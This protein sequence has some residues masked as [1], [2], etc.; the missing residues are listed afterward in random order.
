MNILELLASEPAGLSLSALAERMGL[1]PQTC[2]SLL[3]TLETHNM[4]RQP[5]RGQAYRLGPAIGALARTWSRRQRPPEQVQTA[6]SEL[7]RTTGEYVILA[8]LDGPV[9]IPLAEARPD[10]PLVVAYHQYDTARLHAMATGKLLLAF[11]DEPHREDLLARLEL[12]PWGP[13]SVRNLP[14]LRKQLAMVRRTGQSVC[15]EENAPHVAALAVAVRNGDRQVVAALG[16]ALPTARLSPSR[17]RDL[18]VQMSEAADRIA[19]AWGI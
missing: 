8:Q 10:Q 15:I 16:L 6:V 7:A 17:R 2:Q 18:L 3:R 1:A 9:L 14:Q 12:R 13:R 11:A 5:G 19:E 4:V